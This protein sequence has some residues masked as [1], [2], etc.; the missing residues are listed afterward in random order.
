MKRLFV[1]ICI[2]I[3][4]IIFLNKYQ[5]KD[6]FR[7]PTNEELNKY[8]TEQE[9]SPIVVKNIDQ[10]SLVLSDN[11]FTSLSVYKDSGK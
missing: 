5:S 4:I 8:L 3:A 11:W 7:S 9:I 1:S 6:I 2:I 10:W